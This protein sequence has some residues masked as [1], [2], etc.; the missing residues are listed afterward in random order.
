MR[1]AGL[2]TVFCLCWGLLIFDFARPA[3]AAGFLFHTQAPELDPVVVPVT[4][5]AARERIAVDTVVTTT[6]ANVACTSALC[7]FAQSAATIAPVRPIKKPDIDIG[8]PCNN[9]PRPRDELS[10]LACVSYHEARGESF[11]SKKAA[12]KVV[13]A[14]AKTGWW[15]TSSICGV[16]YYNSVQFAKSGADRPTRPGDVKAWRESVQAAAEALEKK[17]D[18]TMAGHLWTYFHTTNARP[19]W[20]RSRN[21]RRDT[22]VLGR[23]L[24]PNSDHYF[25]TCSRMP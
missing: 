20:R 18:P 21:C 14:R 1:H 7:S 3:Q 15:G 12:A 8:Y 10:C 19:P 23:R 9:D 17:D 24:V 25:Y 2:L 22:E 13:I 11:Q 4:E 16:V 5:P 6:E